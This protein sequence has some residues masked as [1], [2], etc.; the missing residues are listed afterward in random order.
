L[1]HIVHFR[2]FWRVLC[3]T[4]ETLRCRFTVDHRRG[5][6][7]QNAKLII[8]E[9]FTCYHQL[10]FLGRVHLTSLFSVVS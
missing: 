3:K 7:S 5:C 4:I 8:I 6:A 10:R 2:V 1:F 9:Q